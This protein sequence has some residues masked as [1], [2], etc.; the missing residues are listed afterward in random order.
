MEEFFANLGQ[1][2]AKLSFW[3]YPIVFLFAFLESLAFVGVLFPGTILIVVGYLCY[4]GQLHFSLTFLF[5]VAGALLADFIS[6][7]LGKK[8]GLDLKLGQKSIFKYC[9]HPEAGKMLLEGGGLS[10]IVG[11]LIGPTR[12]FVPFYMGAAGEKEKR[13]VLYDLIGVVVWATF[14]LLLGYLFGDSYDLV[15]KFINGAEFLIIVAVIV[16]GSSYLVARIFKK[17]L[18]KL[19]K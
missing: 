14:Y 18:R 13:F 4:L 2:L 17:K 7:H 6:Y 16:F 8:K 12:A 10:I 5:A 19:E 15:K 3:V 1:Y 9:Y 11:R